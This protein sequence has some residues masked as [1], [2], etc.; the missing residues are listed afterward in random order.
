MSIAS[1]NN[2]SIDE[3]ISSP[4]VDNSNKSDAKADVKAAC[5]I[6]ESNFNDYNG[7]QV[8]KKT[9]KPSKSN[10]KQPMISPNGY[11]KLADNE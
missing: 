10:D 9:S 1:S 4:C 7:W 11:E 2:A 6:L 3:T 8:P 5:A